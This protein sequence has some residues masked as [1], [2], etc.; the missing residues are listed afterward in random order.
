MPQ[1]NDHKYDDIIHLPHHTSPTR[2]RMSR[3][4]RAAQF[5][6]FSALTGYDSVVRETARLTD[7][8]IELD[9][10]S[11]TLLNERLQMLSEA[12][13]D[14]PEASITFFE[15]DHQKSG[16]SYQTVSGRVRKI[17]VHEQLLILEDGTEIAFD[18]I[19]DIDSPLFD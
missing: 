6:P 2:P 14:H 11:L 19:Y 1:T 17:K 3:Y 4:D 10:D 15:P 18:R 8:Q 16:G 12:L 13:S 9:E 5:S 7:R